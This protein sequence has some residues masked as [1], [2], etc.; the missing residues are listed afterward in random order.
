MTIT[1]WEYKGN[2]TSNYNEKKLTILN[3]FQKGK[4]EL[5]LYPIKL[6]QSQFEAVPHVTQVFN[7]LSGNVEAPSVMANVQNVKSSVITEIDRIYNESMA[8]YKESLLT[9]IELDEKKIRDLTNLP[10]NWFKRRW[11]Q[12]YR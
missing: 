11:V 2:V 1:T 3:D 7:I 5:N 9:A 10:D 4:I 6:N 12:F 8:T